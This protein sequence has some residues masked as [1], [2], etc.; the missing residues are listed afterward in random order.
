MKLRLSSITQIL[1]T[2]G[3]RLL[4]FD[5]DTL[6]KLA[7]LQ[8]KVFKLELSVL[9]KAFYLVPT[10]TGIQIKDDWS[11]KVDIIVRGSPLALMQFGLKQKGFDNQ[12]FLEKRVVIEGDAE[13]AQDLQKVL[14]ELDIDFEELL[15][16][17]VGDIPAHQIGRGTKLLRAW[18]KEAVNSMQL[19]IREYMVEES[20]ILAPEWRVAAFNEQADTLRADV[21]R[22]DQRVKRLRRI[23]G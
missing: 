1:Q 9:N 8:R 22:L 5:P 14:G 21:E 10:A 18:A 2:T 17:Y 15:A 7:N 23:V 3:N 20:R 19:D 11:D 13:L 16:E 4:Q 6:N 12:V